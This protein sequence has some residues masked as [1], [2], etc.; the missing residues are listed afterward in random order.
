MSTV[1][2]YSVGNGDTFY[3]DHD[4]D[5]FSI[6]DCNLRETDDNKDSILDE[7]AD[8]S[9]KKGI[10]RFISTHPDDDHIH[11]L[12]DL[13]DKINILNFYCVANEA[14]KPNE[15]DHFIHYRSLRDSKKSFKIY[16]GCSRR[17]MNDD[18]DE[19]K[20]SGINIKWP[21]V[22]NEDYNDAL[23]RAKE[24]EEYN[25]ISAIVCYSI[26]NGPSYQWMGDLK[27]EFTE[28]IEEEV[29]WLKTKILFAPH[30]GRKLG[31]LPQRIH[32]KI[33]TYIDIVE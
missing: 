14:T 2:S 10:T 8:L 27:T 30:Q 22:A 24:G 3:I 32:K 25:N 12:E 19:R 1:K 11:G 6:I 29:S 16:K 9:G 20:S 31:K 13:D 4:T 15:D 23:Q 18:D 7:L 33:D 28:K 21:D 17:W 5:N 26:K